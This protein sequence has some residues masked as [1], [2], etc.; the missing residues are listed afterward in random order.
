M[1]EEGGRQ[2]EARERLNCGGCNRGLSRPYQ[3]L[4]GWNSSSQ[5]SRLEAR[6]LSHIYKSLDVTS[7]WKWAR[8]LGKEALFS[9]WEFLEDS[10]QP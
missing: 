10:G 2:E 7:L 3:R 6:G 5:L 8:S 1:C 9:C 4:W